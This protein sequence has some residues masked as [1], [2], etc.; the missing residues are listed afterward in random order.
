MEITIKHISTL[1]K[2]SNN[3]MWM[4]RCALKILPYFNCQSFN[5]YNVPL[6]K[7]KSKK[8]TFTRSKPPIARCSIVRQ[9]LSSSIVNCSRNKK[10]LMRASSIK[11]TLLLFYFLHMLHRRVVYYIY[12]VNGLHLGVESFDLVLWPK[13]WFMGR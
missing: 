12:M 5:S 2:N 11:M 6:H 13:D 1:S 7:Q 10:E 9:R 3:P 4:F 8:A